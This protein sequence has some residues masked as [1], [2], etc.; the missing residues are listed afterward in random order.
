MRTLNYFTEYKQELDK[1]LKHFHR[2][3]S[4]LKSIAGFFLVISCFAFGFGLVALIVSGAFVVPEEAFTMKFL[5]YF[6]NIYVRNTFLIFLGL[7]F[8]YFFLKIL[9]WLIIRK[10]IK[11]FKAKFLTSLVAAHNIILENDQEFTIITQSKNKEKIVYFLNEQ[12]KHIQFI[13]NHHN[14]LS[15][16]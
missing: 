7:S 2:Y 9:D 4:C 3:N 14:D 11:T 1:S 6:N 13:I 10:Q 16:T 15:I 12:S 8:T 5:Y